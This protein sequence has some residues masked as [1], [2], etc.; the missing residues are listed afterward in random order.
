[1]NTVTDFQYQPNEYEA[2]KA[3]NSYL[4]SLAA[5]IA[6][7]PLPI[8]NLIATFIFWVGNR[9]GT[10][11]VRWHSLQAMLSQVPLVAMNSCGFAWT[12]SVIFGDNTVTS[13]YIAYLL[14]IL[15]VNITELVATIYTA[16]AVR[17]GK[18]SEW[19]FYGSLT[20]LLCKR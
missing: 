19:W 1:M 10:Y 12:L 13:A 4:L 7:V 20:N 3:S 11:F 16:I 6:G 2:E 9:K 14:T 5:I 18:H 8:L 17:K 15:T